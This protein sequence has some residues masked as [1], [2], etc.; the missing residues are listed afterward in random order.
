MWTWTHVTARALVVARPRCARYQHGCSHL[1]LDDPSWPT[2]RRA[3]RRRI[4][5]AHFYLARARHT[6]SAHLAPAP[7]LNQCSRALRPV[8]PTWDRALTHWR[9]RCRSTWTS[10]WSPPT[11]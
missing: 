11:A 6:L 8:R 5:D 9:S 7:T 1:Y 3:P 10:H 2:S 4:H